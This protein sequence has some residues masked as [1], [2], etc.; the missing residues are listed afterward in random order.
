MEIMS[1][2]HSRSA[3]GYH[4]VFVTKRRRALL[5]GKV[6]LALKQVLSATA[7][8]CGYDLKLIGSDRDHVHIFVCAAPTVSPSQVAQRLKGGTSREMRRIFPW[9]AARVSKDHLW[10]PNYFVSSVGAISEG[11]L[12]RYIASQGTTA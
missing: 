5:V 6:Y 9:I 7:S 4:F 12:R 3:L 2:N 8:R 10:S 11:A 1:H